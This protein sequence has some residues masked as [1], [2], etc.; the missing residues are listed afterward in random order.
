[1]SERV[2][3]VNGIDAGT[4]EYMLPPLS[5]ATLSRVA[6]GD[7]LDRA[8]LAKLRNFDARARGK[9]FGPRDGVDPKA[10]SESGWGVIFAAANQSSNE[11]IKDALGELLTLREGQCGPLY[12]E[13][14]GA[15]AYR[16]NEKVDAFLARHG[17]A[18][19]S[20]A[21]PAKV[22]YYLLLVGDPE[23]IPYWFQY[24]LDV[25]YAV[26]RL[27]FA[28]LDE[29][30][31][32]ARSVVAAEKG[33]VS[34][35][36]RSVFF[37]VQH[38]DDAATEQSA[39]LL[40]DPLA[41]WMEGWAQERPAGE[42]A[43]EVRRHLAM[44]ASKA[45]LKSLLGGVDTPALLFTASHGLGLQ[46]GDPRQLSHQG[47]LICNDWAGPRSGGSGPVSPDAYLAADDIGDDARLLG[48]IAVN[49]A[50]FSGGTPRWDAFFRQ[51]F[52]AAGAIAPHAFVAR[53]PQRL[54]GH[55]KGGALAVIGHVE[56]AWGCSFLGLEGE[57]HREVFED[58][59]KRLLEGHPVGSA[60]E[61]MNQRYAALAAGLSGEIEQASLG[62]PSL[63]E[64]E[65]ARRWTENNDARGYALLGDPAVRLPV[66]RESAATTERYVIEAV[67]HRDT[68]V[69]SPLAA[70]V[71][72]E[73]AGA[74]P[75]ASG[76]AG[77]ASPAAP[78]GSP[79]LPDVPGVKLAI[80]AIAQRL[81]ALI[82]DTGGVE[83]S[84]HVSDT[85]EEVEPDDAR[86]VM[87]AKRR[88]VTRLL[89]DGG[90]QTH[91]A[92]STSAGD[93]AL[94]ARHAAMVERAQAERRALIEALATALSRLLG[95]R[96]EH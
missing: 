2:F 51:A 17:A 46:S 37:G 83:V 68:P 20:P 49:F 9:H 71:E 75:V 40:V 62:N 73:A 32:Y 34:L 53:L 70:I 3:F 65:L 11:T 36:F 81:L 22:P 18:A 57:P 50:C 79:V 38:K 41:R 29:Y 91:V 66:A 87:G 25:Q 63:H 54:L 47:A 28:T 94:W 89:P 26:G 93:D 77:F 88:M 64:F 84:T 23:S 14:I 4:G 67:T 44:Q 92:E 31:S 43:W 6:R 48:L 74:P 1:M 76:I 5:P 58:M 7:R 95:A 90:L 72:G 86:G 69:P 8:L 56:R 78:K 42:P 10:L 85:M 15:K 59:L 35:P 61:L 27:H 30:A 96:E 45:R 82:D 21:D 19:G 80:E 16:P 39:R 33:R 52:K 60:L 13:Y 55:P 12:R 24:E